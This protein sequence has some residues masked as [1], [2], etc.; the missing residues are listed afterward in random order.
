MLIPSLKAKIGL[1]K[2]AC[3]EK[4]ESVTRYIEELKQFK[5]NSNMPAMK[6]RSLEH[7]HEVCRQ[8]WESILPSN[9]YKCIILPS[10]LQRIIFIL[11]AVHLDYWVESWVGSFSPLSRIHLN[12]LV[13]PLSCFSQ[14]CKRRKAFRWERP[15]LGICVTVRKSTLFHLCQT[16]RD[17]CS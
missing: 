15:N 9:C 8:F 7:V 5:H 17:F 12:V 13:K 10:V 2:K 14:L 3:R 4:D 6:G 1:L 11:K 16:R